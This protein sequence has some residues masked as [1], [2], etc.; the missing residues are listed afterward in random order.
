MQE[1]AALRLIKPIAESQQIRQLTCPPPFSLI[2]PSL[3]PSPSD[4]VSS[5]RRSA[6]RLRAFGVEMKAEHLLPT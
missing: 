2:G 5:R 6:A 4:H 1:T 3:S